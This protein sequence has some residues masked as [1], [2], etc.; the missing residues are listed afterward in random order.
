LEETQIS[1]CTSELEKWIRSITFLHGCPSNCF[2]AAMLCQ[3]HC[4]RRRARRTLRRHPDDR[5]CG[6]SFIVTF[7]SM[8]SMEQAASSRKRFR[9]ENKNSLTYAHKPKHP[10]SLLRLKELVLDAPLASSYDYAFHV[11]VVFI[12]GSQMGF[13]C[14]VAC[15]SIPTN[16]VL[17]TRRLVR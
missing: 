7:D 15:M 1:A 10:R 3:T 11:S 9:H 4:S 8:L 5:T 6:L 12:S 17:V 16:T 2:S 13:V 14:N